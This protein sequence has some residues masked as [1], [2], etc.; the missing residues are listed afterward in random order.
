M[1]KI[2]RIFLFGDSWIEGQGTY[3]HMNDRG[4]P[5][6]PVFNNDTNFDKISN[7]RKENSWNKFV[8]EITNCE[9]INYARQGNSNYTQYSQL[10][11][12]FDKL[13]EHDLV[14]MGF[15]SKLRDRRSIQYVWNIQPNK[16]ISNDNP[17][18]GFVSWEKISLE[19][20]NFGFNRD[21]IDRYSFKTKNEKEF[22]EQF[23]K[24]YIT[25]LHNDQVYEHIAQTNYYFYQERFKSFGLNLVCFDLFEPY[26]TPRYVN[27]HLNIDT[28]V[29]VNY[30]KQTMNEFLQQYEINHI[31]NDKVSI[32]E[33]GYRRPDLKSLIYHPNQHGYKLY[34][35]YLFKKLLHTQY[36][37]N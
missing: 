37:F 17:L 18:N 34:I 22:T 20:Y 23:I 29:Y 10:H 31:T 16:F 7:W 14:V 1:K 28:N 12:I 36:T 3:E 15:T 27:G 24:S 21:N 35:D 2:N 5:F 8:R 19:F 6:E 13:T 9:V 32:W 11:S 30:G 25:F 33:N 26:V 4:E